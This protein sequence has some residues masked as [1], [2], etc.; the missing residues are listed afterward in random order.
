VGVDPAVPASTAAAAATKESGDKVLSSNT[1]L[2]VSVPVPVPPPPPLPPPS[3]DRVVRS[4]CRRP[5]GC[6]CGESSSNPNAKSSSNMVVKTTPPVLFSAAGH[7]VADDDAEDADADA[8]A[9]ADADADDD[10]DE[11][12]AGKENGAPSPS[13]FLL[14]NFTFEWN[15]LLLFD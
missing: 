5:S 15:F 2:S 13:R 11:D 1:S 14:S 7:S 8:Y 4:T 3:D 9:D 12:D 6:G 10:E